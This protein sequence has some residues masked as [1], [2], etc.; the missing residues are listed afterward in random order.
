ML[1]DPTMTLPVAPKR[2]FPGERCFWGVYCLLLAAIVGHAA[3]QRFML[4]QTPIVDPD[5]WGYL[6][7][8]FSKLTG[9]PFQHTYGRNFVYPGFL[10][11]L[12]RVVGDY[13]IIGVVQHTLGLLTGVLLAGGWNVLCGCLA[14]PGW[15]RM[16]A[17]LA[18]LGLVADFLFSRSPLLFE[19]TVRPEAVFPFFLALS[20][21]LNLAALHAGYVVRRP[22]LERWCLG[23]NFFVIAT[24]QS[25]KPSLGF[26]V[27]TAN[28]PLAA[29]LLRGGTPWRLKTGV[30]GVAIGVTALT[31]WLPERWW[32]KSDPLTALFLP[33]TLFV[34]HA[35]PI[36]VQ[37]VDDLRTG[38]TAPYNPASLARF[39]TQLEAALE[40][41]ARP[42]QSPYRTLGYNPDYLMYVQ[43]VFRPS[44]DYD[45]QTELT[46]FCMFYYRRAWVRAPGPMLAKI[47]AQLA[48]VYNLRFHPGSKHRLRNWFTPP[49]PEKGESLSND[50]RSSL[51]CTADRQAAMLAVPGGGSYLTFLQSLQDV[52]AVINEPGWVQAMNALLSRWHLPLLGLTLVAGAALLGCSW[53]ACGPLVAGV[54]LF[55]LVNFSMFLTVAIVHSLE[56]QRYVENQ[57]VCTVFGECLTGLLVW[58]GATLLITRIRGLR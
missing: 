29:F 26:G 5:F 43:P 20:F 13:R 38:R 32:A 35:K 30:A 27:L 50:Y 47:G 33:E 17:R 52:P 42:E 18:G 3:R 58:Q 34:I 51:A 24:A 41:A 7:P 2:A 11:L 21:L 9:G 22:R 28:G 57:R 39:N 36:H 4:P 46:E 44:F 8:A 23:L 31:L 56:P 55:W 40:T 37:I 49:P 14:G 48:E 1:T 6:N 10:Y 45:E 53:R 25:L 12:L 16:A 54:W 19:H 15:S